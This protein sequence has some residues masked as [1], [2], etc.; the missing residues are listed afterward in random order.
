MRLAAAQNTDPRMGPSHSSCPL[1]LLLLFFLLASMLI[2]TCN[3]AEKPPEAAASAVSA[4]AGVSWQHDGATE[5]LR[6]GAAQLPRSPRTNVEHCNAPPCGGRSPTAGEPNLQ[7]AGGVPSNY[8][9]GGILGG[10]NA[11]S[12]SFGDGSMRVHL[13]TPEQRHHPRSNGGGCGVARALMASTGD[14]AHERSLLARQLTGA[15]L[16]PVSPS[17]SSL[18]PCDAALQCSDGERW[19]LPILPFGPNNQA[20]KMRAC[21]CV[22]AGFSPPLLS[23]TVPEDSVTSLPPSLPPSL[24]RSLSPCLP[25]CP[26]CLPCLPACLPA[27]LPTYQSTNRF[28]TSKKALRWVR[29]STALSCCR[30]SSSTPPIAPGGGG[31]RALRAGT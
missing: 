14:A 21:V 22:F 20:R 9:G 1:H 26:A 27:D 2:D 16:S 8:G 12:S 17:S 25:A 11:G 24:A 7:R 15:S 29:C 31:G 6:N 30:P 23:V 4:A 28:S 19:L 3:C 10:D 13:P 5:L 18:S